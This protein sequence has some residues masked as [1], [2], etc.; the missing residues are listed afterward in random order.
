[1]WGWWRRREAAH[2]R[3]LD[4]AERLVSTAPT[5]QA[6]LLARQAWETAAPDGPEAA[7]ARRVFR[8]V[9]RRVRPGGD[10]ATRMAQRD[11]RI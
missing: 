3:V 9:R 5:G 11:G 2:Q 6:Y 1:M 7:H 8:E 4:E 10:T